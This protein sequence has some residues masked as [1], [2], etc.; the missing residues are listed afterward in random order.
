MFAG[1]IL[2][3]VG[4][5]LL[6]LRFILGYL[7][8]NSVC[9]C[10]CQCLLVMLS[11][12]GLVLILISLLLLMSKNSS[13]DKKIN[14]LTTLSEKINSGSCNFDKNTKETTY[15]TVKADNTD[16]SVEKVVETTEKNVYLTDAIKYIANAISEI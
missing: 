3:L 4:F 11:V 15:K 1:I 2:E 16:K 12:T 6:T 5:V 7:Y 14:L 8:N 10:N 9:S 13:D